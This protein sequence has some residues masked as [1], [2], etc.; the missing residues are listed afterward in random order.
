MTAI[1]RREFVKKSAGDVALVALLPMAAREARA[2]PLG[3]PIGS[4]TWPHRQR[5][6][7]GDFG[8]C[9]DCES[10]IGAKRL[11]AV[12]WAGCWLP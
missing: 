3:L 12:P 7:N 1:S 10:V 9:I 6:R 8:T 11:S 5:I 4:Q 2:N